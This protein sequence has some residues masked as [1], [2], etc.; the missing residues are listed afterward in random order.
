MSAP[1]SFALRHSHVLHVIT[2]IK[3]AVPHSSMRAGS[4]AMQSTSQAKEAAQSGNGHRF[5]GQAGARQG[6]ARERTHPAGQVNGQGYQSICK[7]TLTQRAAQTAR[8]PW[9]AHLQGVRAEQAARALCPACAAAQPPRLCPGTSTTRMRR[10]AAGGGGGGGGGAAPNPARAPAQ[11][12][13]PLPVRS[14]AARAA[15]LAGSW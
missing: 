1:R 11:S 2:S 6:K 12:S 3:R 4:A 13:G 5:A 10:R 15:V 7:H 14:P 8:A 9:T